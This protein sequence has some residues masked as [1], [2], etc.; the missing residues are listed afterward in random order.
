[1][2]RPAQPARGVLDRLLLAVNDHDL[3]ALVACFAPQYVNET[4][5]HPLRGFRGLEQVRT[6]W[7]QIFAG[8][9]DV[10]AE[11][12]RASMSGDTLWT[13]WV[14]DG[15]RADGTPV[16]MRGVVVFV[17]ADDTFVSA[18]FYLEP[19]EETSGD[20]NAQTRRLVGSTS[21]SASGE[22]S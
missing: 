20:V 7:S 12:P 21:G 16:G 3:D 17:V 15:H 18:T 1:M 19:L 4:P 10:R 6:N 2:D 8:I 9:P 11:V 5:A 13:E 14:I 22:A